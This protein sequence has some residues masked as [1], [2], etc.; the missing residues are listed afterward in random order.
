MRHVDLYVPSEFSRAIALWLDL[1]AGPHRVPLDKPV[2]FT[3]VASPKPEKP[4]KRENSEHAKDGD[5]ADVKPEEKAVELK[6][7]SPDEAQIGS[8]GNTES[9]P[10]A[11]DWTKLTVA[12]LKV[13]LTKRGLSTKGNKAELVKRIA[14]ADVPAGAQHMKA[15][16]FVKVFLGKPLTVGFASHERLR[17]RTG[18]KLT[19]AGDQSGA[20]KAGAVVFFSM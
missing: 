13:E 4:E 11:K 17:Q 2:K 19:V 6:T 20:Y 7:E 15:I 12:G 3:I 16:F 10:T 8:Q 1:L 14:E 9:S 5:K 18:R